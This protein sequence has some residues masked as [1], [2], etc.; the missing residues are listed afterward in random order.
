MSG[1]P[2]GDGKATLDPRHQAA[3]LL[4]EWRLIFRPRT[5]LADTLAAVAVALVALPL[6]LAISN[7]SGV[8]PGVGLITAVVG[9]VVAALLG[10]VASRSPDRRR[11]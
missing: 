4:N 7:A 1:S 2:R 10:G 11:P 6:S 9:G 8:S 3:Y 5:I